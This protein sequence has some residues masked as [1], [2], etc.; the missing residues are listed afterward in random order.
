MHV[1]FDDQ[2]FVQQS[3]GGISRYFTELARELARGGLPV[4]LFAGIAWN[5]SGKRRACL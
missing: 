2:I 5:R 1:F 4:R 3:E